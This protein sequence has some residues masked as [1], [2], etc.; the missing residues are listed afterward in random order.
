[1]KLKQIFISTMFGLAA[2]KLATMIYAAIEVKIPD[3]NTAQELDEFLKANSLA[4]VEFHDLN[5]PVCQ[6][7]QRKGIFKES[8]AALPHIK[9]AKVSVQQGLGLHKEYQIHNYPTFIFFKNE[10]K[11]EF[12]RDGKKVDRFLGY[13]DNPMFTRK[14]GDIFA[15]AELADKNGPKQT[16]ALNQK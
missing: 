14:V 16:Q 4:V 6:A 9:F 15:Q 1:M 11:I 7:F 13:V 2:L 8:A 5:C 3:I 12:N 10:K